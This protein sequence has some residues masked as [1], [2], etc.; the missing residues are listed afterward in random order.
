MLLGARIY[1]CG[2]WRTDTFCQGFC[3][4]ATRGK[5]PQSLPVVSISFLRTSLAAPLPWPGPGGQRT[6][7]SKAASSS[8]LRPPS[9][10]LPRPSTPA[11]PRG[12]ET[13]G[14]VSPRR[15]G[16]RSEGRGTRGGEDRERGGQSLSARG[17]GGVL[18]W[19]VLSPTAGPGWSRRTARQTCR[20]T[21]PAKPRGREGPSTETVGGPRRSSGASAAVRRRA[22]A[23]WANCISLHVGGRSAR[24]KTP[25][26][27]HTFIR[28]TT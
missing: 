22:L 8:Q 28:G 20:E 4:I 5:I 3:S 2:K 26:S 15:I 14:T 6:L 11:S 12:P 10:V 19:R 23:V 18:P 16:G 21:A 1:F 13:S 17:T 25:S 24:Y 7:R 27:C 9:H